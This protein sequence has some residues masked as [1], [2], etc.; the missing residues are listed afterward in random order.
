VT[1]TD[2]ATDRR[3]GA[4]QAAAL[5]RVSMLGA[6]GAPVAEIR[7][8]ITT[9]LEGLGIEEARSVVLEPGST[10]P[11]HDEPVVE[12]FRGLLSISVRAAQERAG[13][14]RLVEEHQALRALATLAARGATA[15]ELFAAAT[16]TVGEL[17]G[18]EIAALGRFGAHDS[19][20]YIACWSRSG[21]A[22]DLPDNREALSATAGVRATV[23]VDGRPW[24]VLS[25]SF[26]DERPA[27][28]DTGARLAPFT[29]LLAAAVVS[30]GTRDGLTL[31]ADEH[32]ALR[33]VATLVAQGAPREEV[34]SALT[35][36]AALHLGADITSLSRIDDGDWMTTLATWRRSGDPI[37]TARWPL[38]GENMSIT[39]ART[40]RAA[41]ND[42]YSTATG[43]LAEL[44]R[45]QG[46]AQGVAVPVI[47]EDRVW[48]VMAAFSE[49]GRA[50]PTDTE[51]R[52]GEF[53]ALLGI[54]I[55]NTE[56]RRE[57]AA[58][59]ARIVATTDGARRRIERDLHDGAQQR[60][61]SLGLE[62][63]G[64]LAATPPHLHD[65]RRALADI[66]TGLSDAQ[67]R[68][69]EIAHGVHPA[70]LAE[71]G[72][73]PALKSLSRQSATP[74][75][76][77]V[78]VPLRLS[79]QIEVAGYYVV[80]EALE[81]AD[82]HAQAKSVTVRVKVVDDVLRI[83]VRDDGVGGADPAAGSG[84]VGLRDRVETVSGSF[85]VRSRAGAGTTLSVEIPLV[86]A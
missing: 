66:S 56:T 23:M 5:R 17:V 46:A 73:G 36:E 41:R 80:R 75:M 6:R 45:S 31:L 7:A 43:A 57:L 48:G 16:H 26:P 2:S 79:E 64:A 71:S 50:L 10:A 83:V 11:P 78:S 39:V 1:E 4:E 74:V 69:R 86:H 20:E 70:I 62:L 19:V 52:L 77:D 84:L 81:N 42:D 59:R 72:L 63:Q 30:A 24:G 51:Q 32:A 28:A 40:G 55:A 67:D 61:V 13:T 38:S 18:A 29:E 85:S 15:E 53:T 44:V 21:D 9:E 37:A 8:A 35:K 68:L 54:A 82:K 33:R 3:S 25:V 12:A 14:Q 47:V 65:L 27:A 58:S 60:L 34:Y 76:L 49:A 22:V